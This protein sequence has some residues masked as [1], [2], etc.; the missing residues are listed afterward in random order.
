[1]KLSRLR[2]LVISAL[3]LPPAWAGTATDR[4]I[5]KF[6][7]APEAGATVVRVKR[8]DA[9]RQASGAAM[10]P[11]REL[12]DGA[13]VYQLPSSLD[14]A[15]AEQLARKIAADP[16][17]AYAEPDRIRK[18][19]LMPNDPYR[20]NQWQLYDTYGARLTSAWDVT[21]GSGAV[22]IALVDTGYLPH[23][24]LSGRFLP[25]YDFITDAFIANDGDGRDDQALDPGDWVTQAE[26]D[27]NPVCDGNVPEDSSWHGLMVAGIAGA[28]GN[29]AIGVAGMNWG[30]RLLPV[31][32][33]G[34]CGGY[35]SDI[36]DGM[37]WAAGFDVP[38]IPTNPTPAHII[39]VSFGSTDNCQVTEQNA[40]NAIVAAG[41]VVVAAAGNEE[42]DVKTHS[43][44]NCANVIAVGATTRSGSRASYSNFGTGITVSAPV[45][46][47]L[48][49]AVTERREHAQV[50]GVAAGE[51]QR[52]RQAAEAR[53]ARFRFAVR[54]HVPA[55]Q[56]RGAGPYAERV[57][58]GV[59]RGAQARI[60]GQAEVVVAGEVDEPAAVHHRVRRL[61]RGE[62]AP[63]AAKVAALELG[64]A[65]PQALERP[66]HRGIRRARGRARRRARRRA[67][68]AGFPW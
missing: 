21:T 66:A 26:I 68:P 25:G 53:E 18:R 35:M 7:P 57:D 44:S 23:A 13:Q 51:E 36:I 62:H 3:L 56:R 2:L 29:N 4:M 43:P 55:H 1:M 41:K 65:L 64:Q 63:A 50:R 67:R 34:K 12:A 27:A 47:D 30:V 52:R 17:V 48:P 59:R 28:T 40:I 11:L 6:K 45:G 61:G 15:S 10:V 54:L 14:I 31:R 22:V 42:A 24:D 39:N 8:A 46:E 58:R 49:V 9:V 37:Y 33:L 19:A 20:D 38:G 60:G 16:S 32:A 5:V